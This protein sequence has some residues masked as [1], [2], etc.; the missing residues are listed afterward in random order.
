MKKLLCIISF[1]SIWFCFWSTIIKSI[2]YKN[3]FEDRY[4]NSFHL[5]TPTKGLMN[6][7]QGGFY[8]DGIWHLYI[9]YNSKYSNNHFGMQFDKYGTVLYHI[10]TQDWVN[11]N[12]IGVALNNNLTS[13][14]DISS[15]TVYEDR[16]N[17]FGYGENTIIVMAS[18]FA[19]NEQNILGYYSTDG[20]YNF[21][22]I[23]QTPIISVHQEVNGGDFRDPFF[24][25]KD[26]KYIMYIAQNEFFGVWV[27]DYPTEGYVK[28]GNYKA[29]HP[30]LEC[31]NLYQLKVEGEETKKWVLLYGG[32]GGWGVDKDDL[33]SGT[34][35]TIGEIDE[36]FTFKKDVDQP[37][38]RLDYGPD[39]Y[40]ANYF[41]KSFSNTNLKELICGGWIGNWNY[42][43]YQPND[44][45][46]GNMSLARIL[47]LRRKSSSS[48]KILALDTDFIEKNANIKSDDF[49]NQKEIIIKNAF[50]K[51]SINLNN[52][53]N[54]S[55]VFEIGDNYYKIKINLDFEKKQAII[56]RSVEDY[57]VNKNEEFY[58]TRT[59]DVD[60][61]VKNAKNFSIYLDK[62]ILELEFPDGK[63]FTIS[64]FKG[65][66]SIEV[67]KVIFDKQSTGKYE[68]GNFIN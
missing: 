18:S 26:G 49:I 34:Y 20:G 56:N 64:K 30:M 45:R 50:E 38:V 36:N 8:R 40:A 55:I 48:N 25:V 63:K 68:Y 23:Q 46:V 21:L 43:N 44:G 28:K 27:S 22:P 60:Y 62:T 6:D 33:S 16:N 66:K 3:R 59:F 10:T 35:Y 15:G 47:K 13:Y 9:L 54:N 39:F 5:Q 7:I 24:F 52:L 41:K 17:Y 51:F 65:T 57:F 61:D 11:F 58:K 12:Y 14:D 53:K 67:L 2:N 1:F 42:L 19:K 31:P 4:T 32:N 29:S 37:I